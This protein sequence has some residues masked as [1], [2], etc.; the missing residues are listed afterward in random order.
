M[1]T[2]GEMSEN[3]SDLRKKFWLEKLA[4]PLQWH[5]WTEAELEDPSFLL[6]HSKIQ[7]ALLTSR[8]S[9]P[10]FKLAARKPTE[11][12]E[13][14]HA[15]SVIY[16][17]GSVWLRCFLRIALRQLIMEAS[18]SLNTHATCYITG[19]GSLT[20][21]CAVVAI[22]MGFRHLAFVA[23]EHH[24]AAAEIRGLQRLFFDLEFKL[25][26]ENELTL[27]PNNGSLLINTLPAET[28]GVIF[29][30]LTYLNF[31]KKE[32]LVVDLPLSFV[33]NP[34]LEEAA[35]AELVFLESFKIWGVRD[36]LFLQSLL[37]D[38]LTITLADYLKEWESFAKTE[39]QT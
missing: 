7:G 32:G 34:L 3:P 38:Q 30:D 19:T 9:D 4:L 17:Q 15:D 13:T 37:A 28:G 10:L 35:Q 36:W 11:V 12:V 39:K 26:R 24:E 2:V 33:S 1:I 23:S 22:Q 5:E 16:Q 18:P 29:E 21:M 27:Q 14:G 31:L 25:L 6:N 20:R 8:Y